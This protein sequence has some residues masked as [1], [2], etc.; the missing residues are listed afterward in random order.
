MMI[1]SPLRSFLSRSD[2]R[3]AHSGRHQ[4]GDLNALSWQINGPSFA[5]LFQRFGSL[6]FDGQ[7][8]LSSGSVDLRLAEIVRNVLY[9]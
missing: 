2:V 3:D 6:L 8:F 5:H 4:A 7:T 1:P 9:F